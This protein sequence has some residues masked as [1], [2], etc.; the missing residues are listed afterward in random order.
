MIYI[1]ANIIIIYTLKYYQ[2]LDNDYK[3]NK[4][5]QYMCTYTLHSCIERV[6][7]KGAVC[8]TL[9]AVVHYYIYVIFGQYKF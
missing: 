2:T 3:N 1:L 8:L 6:F 5:P 9:S 4:E 7:S